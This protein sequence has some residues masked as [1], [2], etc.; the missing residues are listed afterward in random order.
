MNKNLGVI[1]QVLIQIGQGVG[2]L[3]QIVVDGSQ[4][5]THSPSPSVGYI[6]IESKEE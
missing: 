5:I 6:F 2:V 4:V 1:G 3:G